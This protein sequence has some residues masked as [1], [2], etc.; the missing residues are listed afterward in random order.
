MIRGRVIACTC[1]VVSTNDTDGRLELGLAA[2]GAVYAISIE[3]LMLQAQR[4][5]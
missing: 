1:A 5:I 3:L 4:R 2:R